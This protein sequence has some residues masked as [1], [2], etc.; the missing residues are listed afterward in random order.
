MSKINWTEE[1]TAKL[2]ELAGS[3][4][5]EQETLISIAETLETTPRSI[6]A[7]LRNMNYE[8]AKAAPRASAWTDE[9][10]AALEAL[11]NANPEELTYAEIAKTFAGGVFTPQQVQ[12]KILS[13]ELF[14][15]IRKAEK[16]VPA[17]LYTEDEEAKFISLAKGGATMEALT[18]AL[19]KSISSIRGKALS[20]LRGGLID[21]VPV[22]EHS[23]AQASA[24]VLGGID[25]ENL[26]VAEIAEAA[27]RSERGI[28]ST[29][30][31]RGLTCKDYDGA[32]KRAKL[33]SKAESK[34]TAE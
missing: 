11:V 16:K 26:T 20:L 25:V 8:V 18:E 6:G 19:G 30:S 33:D 24:D 22:Q 10:A 5:V 1:K 31:R 15:K 29:L 4:I 28:K 32:A 2:V 23:V 34:T 14:G 17:R 21:S 27:D 7:K 9:Q 3:G 13:M 12:G